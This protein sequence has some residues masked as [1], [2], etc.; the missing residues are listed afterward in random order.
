MNEMKY[1]GKPYTT[2]KDLKLTHQ[3]PDIVAPAFPGLGC[4]FFA[5][6]FIL[7]Y[8][9]RSSAIMIAPALCAYN[10]RLIMSRFE[11]SNYMIENNLVFFLYE[12]EDIIQGAEETIKQNL[13]DFCTEKKPDVVF[14]VTSCLPE[15]VGEDVEAVAAQ[16]RELVKVPILVIRT[17]N[18]TNISSKQGVERTFE[19][20]MGLMENPTQKIPRSV[21]IIGNSAIRH[22]NTELF[23]ILEKEGIIIN[24]VIPSHISVQDIRKAPEAMY[25][26]IVDRGCLPLAEK[27]KEKY[28]IQYFHYDQAYS[29]DEILKQYH[30][31]GSFLSINIEPLVQADYEN[32]Q[33]IIFSL[34]KKVSGKKAIISMNN[35]RVFDAIK[36]LGLIGIHIPVVTIDELNEQDFMDLEKLPDQYNDTHIIRN[37]SCY[38][39]EEYLNQIKPD[40]Y[41]TYGGYEQKMCN[42]YNIHYHNLHPYMYINGFE[43]SIQILSDLFPIETSEIANKSGDKPTLG[44]LK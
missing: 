44:E 37:I 34:R 26:I 24:S 43:R 30:N 31:L 40:Y 4:G 5:V 19:A 16:V 2:I 32:F 38:P 1:S 9:A 41:L 3:T 21:N 35:A 15:I 13:L 25:N 17:E 10:A 14:I 8:I 33:S 28:D 7:P 39:L 11:Q 20:L 29:P 27:M 6:S 18:F 22:K 23:R 36:L 42:E 12:E